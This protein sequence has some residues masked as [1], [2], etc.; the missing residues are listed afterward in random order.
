MS[1]CNAAP[2][3]L[4]A[5][6]TQRI[7]SLYGHVE[8]LGPTYDA[9]FIHFSLNLSA[10][11]ADSQNDPVQAG[12]LEYVKAWLW[13]WTELAVLGVNAEN[14]TV[15][16]PADAVDVLVD[17]A[18]APGSSSPRSSARRRS[19]P[20]NRSTRF[21][22]VSRRRAIRRP[23]MITS[24][25]I[26][27]AFCCMRRRWQHPCRTPGTSSC[28][29]LQGQCAGA[30]RRRRRRTGG[31]AEVHSWPA[32][33]EHASYPVHY[34]P[35]RDS[36]GQSGVPRP[37]GCTAAFRTTYGSTTVRFNFPSPFH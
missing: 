12:D 11:I 10:A 19:S 9:G 22:R 16:L 28:A 31:G 4:A 34:D 36:G 26:G 20:R 6:S 2:A 13:K 27:R 1:A 5:L 18:V 32:R 24:G 15:E 17:P 29:G 35:R 8:R 23:S 37:R 25:V 3:T 7:V 14:L 21:A 30:H 33:H